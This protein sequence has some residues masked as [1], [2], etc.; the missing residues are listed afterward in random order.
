MTALAAAM[1]V[2]AAGFLAFFVYLLTRA[3]AAQGNEGGR[4]V[5]MVLISI[6]LCLLSVPLWALP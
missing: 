1:D 4:P 6:S 2:V 5:A 3:G